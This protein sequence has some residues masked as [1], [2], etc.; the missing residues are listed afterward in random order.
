MQRNGWVRRP[1]GGAGEPWRR[2]W[3]L[4]QRM[5][6]ASIDSFT[7]GGWLRLGVRSVDAGRL[8]GMLER[9]CWQLREGAGVPAGARE[10]RLAVEGGDRED[11]AALAEA[12]LAAVAETSEEEYWGESIA[13]AAPVAPGDDGSLPDCEEWL[14]RS[15][16]TAA[17]VRGGGDAEGFGAGGV[18]WALEGC[19]AGC[20]ASDGPF[21]AVV[22]EAKKWAAETAGRRVWVWCDEGQW[23]MAAAGDGAAALRARLEAGGVDAAGPGVPGSPDAMKE[24]LSVTGRTVVAAGGPEATAVL[25]RRYGLWAAPSRLDAGDSRANVFIRGKIG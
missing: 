17:W 19:E 18:Y 10:A 4:R 14:G 5:A 3:G 6:R 2:L 7:A 25:V 16:A 21:W 24:A 9:W 13:L 8:G 1:A 20:E 23:W 15:V 12:V 22:S 11:R